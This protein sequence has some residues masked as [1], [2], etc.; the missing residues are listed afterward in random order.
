MISKENKKFVI[1]VAICFFILFVMVAFISLDKRV[2]FCFLFDVMF[3]LA[4]LG[5]YANG[6]MEAEI[7]IH[8]IKIDKL[9]HLK[10]Y[11]ES[12]KIKNGKP[13]LIL[14]EII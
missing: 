3:P 11:L 14:D 10:E 8:N 2:W 5:G 4:I 6:K 12:E 9:N 13:V 7:E 1:I